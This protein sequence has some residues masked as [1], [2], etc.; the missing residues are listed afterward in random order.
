MARTYHYNTTV[1]TRIWDNKENAFIWV[2][3]QIAI[4]LDALAF[5]LG[6][7]A[8]SAKTRQ[9]KLVNGAIVAKVKGRKA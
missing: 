8:Y 5:K 1:D 6:R 2:P 3:V 4:D 9:S 7:K